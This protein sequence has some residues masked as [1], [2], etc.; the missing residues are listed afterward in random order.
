MSSLALSEGNKICLTLNTAETSD[1]WER[2]SLLLLNLY[3]DEAL[4]AYSP[5]TSQTWCMVGHTILH[6]IA[7]G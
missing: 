2:N 3:V 5:D 1:V 7:S 6:K 4:Y